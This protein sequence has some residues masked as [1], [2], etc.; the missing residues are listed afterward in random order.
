MRS[1]GKVMVLIRVFP[2]SID[3]NLQE[4]V[5]KIG[6]S[7]PKEYNLVNYEEE[8]I[9][10]GLKA[11]N[12]LIT[13]P[14]LKEGGTYELEQIISKIEGVSEIEVLKVTRML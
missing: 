13:M 2:E 12:I 6:E 4:L 3:I 1:L 14:E 11:L 9:A 7:L 5:K 10:F 8:P